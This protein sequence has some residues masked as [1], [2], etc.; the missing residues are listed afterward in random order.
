MEMPKY[1][2]P[3]EEEA[4]DE[5]HMLGQQRWHNN[6]PELRIMLEHALLRLPNL[7]RSTVACCPSPYELRRH[8]F[9]GFSQEPFLKD[10]ARE[11]I[12][13]SKLW[14]VWLTPELSNIKHVELEDACTLACVEAIA[15]RS[16][17][18][19]VKPAKT[20]TLD[21]K[22]RQNLRNLLPSSGHTE[23]AINDH[24]SKRQK[25]LQAFNAITDLTLRVR[26]AAPHA[27]END[28]QAGDI[29]QIL[30]AAKSARTL[31]LEY[32]NFFDDEI[33]LLRGHIMPQFALMPLLAHPKVTYPH[34]KEAFISAVVSGKALAGFLRLH[35]PT[36]K[37]LGLR[38]SISDDWATVYTQ[39]QNT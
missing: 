13:P 16:T 19:A 2:N 3:D 29:Q 36:L 1:V 15:H 8:L 39:S 23:D 18:S 34:L 14:L 6:L 10:L 9:Q 37:S 12:V 25:S 32:G 5:K 21:L 30:E 24:V 35:S 17:R 28:A 7:C 20:L 11:I 27:S 26:E 31:R 33:C 38:R 22:S 4:S